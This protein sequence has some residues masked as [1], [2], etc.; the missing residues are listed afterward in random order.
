[1]KT[2]YEIYDDIRN[3]KEISNEDLRLAVLMYRDL[4]WFANND[5]EQ[6]YKECK[7]SVFAKLRFEQNVRRY[8][9]ALQ[10]TPKEFLGNNGIPRHKR[11]ERATR[12]M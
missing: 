3:C 2:L 12:I 4:L 1:M 8:K 10:T 11:M 5:V 6:L 7:N 9:R